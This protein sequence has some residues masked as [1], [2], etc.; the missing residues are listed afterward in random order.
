M[1]KII[2]KSVRYAFNHPDAS[3]DYVKVHAQEM[4]DGVIDQHIGLYV[5]DDSEH[6]GPEGQ[7]AIEMLFKKARQ[8]GMMPE[9]DAELFAC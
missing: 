1:E 4:E 5:N 9:N 8:A 7:A 6:I 2:Q 3:R